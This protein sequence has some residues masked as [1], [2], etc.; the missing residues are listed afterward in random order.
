MYRRL[1]LKYYK[2]ENGYLIEHT[3][4]GTTPQTCEYVFNEWDDMEK[5]LIEILGNSIREKLVR[6]KDITIN[7][8]E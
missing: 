1:V 8:G 5:K 6:Q 2:T 7:F 4:E 3:G